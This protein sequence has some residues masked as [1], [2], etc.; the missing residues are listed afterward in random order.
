MK[1]KVIHVIIACNWRKK[2]VYAFSY[3]DIS[4]RNIIKQCLQGLWYFLIKMNVW[5]CFRWKLSRSYASC[6]SFIISYSF[7]GYEN[8]WN[9]SCCK[10]PPRSRNVGQLLTFTHT[11]QHSATLFIK[12]QNIK[13]FLTYSLLAWLIYTWK[14][15]N[16]NFD[17]FRFVLRWY[18]RWS[19]LL[20][21][22]VLVSSRI[23]LQ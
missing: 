16:E 7:A 23:D 22:I 11:S 4:L 6:P 18:W 8:P 2:L 13:L 12:I 5:I 14:K 21:S 19:T 1:A 10:F 9:D 15:I 3:C 17:F 20:L